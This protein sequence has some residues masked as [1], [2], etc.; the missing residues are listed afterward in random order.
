MKLLLIAGAGTSV[1]LGVPGMV[2]M[3]EEFLDH[4]R[5]WDV[6]ADLVERLMGDSRDVEHLIE[7]LDQIS[8]ARPHLAMMEYALD[9]LDRVDR[10]R[11]E[12]EW[13]IQHAAERVVPRDAR[14][15][16]GTV[17]RAAASVDLTLVTT[18]YDRA[19]E[20]A[21][22]AEE[23]QVDDGFGTWSERETASWVGFNREGNRP[24][25]V[26]IHGS[27]D[28]YAAGAKGA[29]I[30]L[31][32]PM[33]LF[34]R[35]S[36]RLRDGLEL[37]SALVL[38]SREKLLTHNPYPRLSQAF[39]NAADHCDV[40]VI[41]GSSLRD[42]HVRGVVES[43]AS[44]VPVF[45]VNPA[46]DAYGIELGT[47]ITQCAS[48]FLISTLP[49]ALLSADP[50]STLRSV[51]LIAEA[52][53]GVMGLVR[54]SLDPDLPTDNRCRAL[55]ELDEKGLTLAPLQLK[56]LLHDTDPTVARYALGLLSGSADRVAL[57]E[58]AA[59]TPHAS[60]VAFREDLDMLRTIVAEAAG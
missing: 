53:V 14:L 42:H 21:A 35:A 28:W 48:T 51:V 59:A 43:M 33:P 3:G 8:T 37:S 44:R 52:D 12:I 47:V 34:G 11:A 22:N 2:G 20:L 57:F 49:N 50:I 36:L 19:I 45:L 60:Q 16:W 25:L 54:R 40:A 10:I 55:E 39:L 7:A 56:Q 13:F 6:E 23:V 58:A 27:T 41:V 32:H 15:M 9:S 31:R 30:K 29:A 17:L 1:E 5:Q 38:P 18:N 24:L 4:V 26:K 46:G